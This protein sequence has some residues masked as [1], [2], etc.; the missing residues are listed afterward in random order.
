MSNEQSQTTRYV[1]WDFEAGASPPF[2]HI[3]STDME[4]GELDIGASLF[5][6]VTPETPKMDAKISAVCDALQDVIATAVGTP[7]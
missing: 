1:T 4:P 7:R 6:I 5:T 3:F 2:Y